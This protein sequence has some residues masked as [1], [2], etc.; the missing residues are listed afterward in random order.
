MHFIYIIH[1]FDPYFALVR[2][3][4]IIIRNAV[5]TCL[6]FAFA[7]LCCTVYA[8]TLFRCFFF[9][10][11]SASDNSFMLYKCKAFQWMNKGKKR[12]E[13]KRRKI[14]TKRKHQEQ[15]TTTAAAA[16]KVISKYA[17]IDSP[18]WSVS[19]GRL[20]IYMYDVRTFGLGMTKNALHLYWIES[21]TFS[22][23][24]HYEQVDSFKCCVVHGMTYIYM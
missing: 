1:D 11:A 13:K 21:I 14:T 15:T 18:V 5:V 3:I 9:N 10:G 12:K 7:R 16:S 4:I 17:G 23:P 24:F 6:Y 22:I 19:M 20:Y 2:F 8:F